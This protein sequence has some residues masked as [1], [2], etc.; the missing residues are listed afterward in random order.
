MNPTTQPDPSTE[1]AWERTGPLWRRSPVGGWLFVCDK[2]PSITHG[3]WG[4]VNGQDKHGREYGEKG[5]AAADAWAK[6]LSAESVEQAR[7]LAQWGA[8]LSDDV[9]GDE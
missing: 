4:R 7:T 6:S 9:R 8:C 2:A 1:P 5:R 3:W